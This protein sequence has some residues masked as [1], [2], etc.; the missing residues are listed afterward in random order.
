MPGAWSTLRNQFRRQHR[1]PGREARVPPDTRVYA[2]GDIHGRLDLLR[3]LHALI[4][5]DAATVPGRRKTIVY[6]GDYVDRGPESRGV[7]D[8]LLD[9]TPADLAPVW[10]KGNHEDAL[11]RFLDGFSVG[12]DWLQFGG[13][14]TL[15]SYGVGLAGSPY[16]RR[17]MIDARLTLRERLP[18]RH[19]GFLRGLVTRFEFGGYL[20]VHAGVRPGVALDEQAPDDLIWIRD[21]FLDS[22]ADH[23]RVVVHGH[24]ISPMVENLANRINIDTGAYAT[25]TLTCLVLDGAERRLLQT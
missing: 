2:V 25:G 11:I 22:K 14:E 17:N 21:E 10:L 12:W 16:G 1:E 4:A 8:C 24:S 3:G 15:C 9:E 20:F 23:G 13:E 5:A 19:L 7:I 18:E 6:L